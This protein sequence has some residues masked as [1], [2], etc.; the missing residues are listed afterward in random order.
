MITPRR[1]QAVLA[2]AALVAATLVVPTGTAE[3]QETLR[4][5]ADA[6]GLRM[7]A[8]VANDPLSGNTQ[9]RNIL[10]TEFNSVTA[11]NSMKWE[12]LQPSEGQFNWSQGDAIVEFAQDNNQ[13]VY[14]HTLVWHSQAPDW[15]QNLQGQQ[16]DSAMQTHISTVLNHYQGDVEAW[17][18]ANEVIDDDGD[19]RDSFWLEG[20]GP[21]YIADAFRYADA[22][23]PNAKLYINDYSID[24][25]NTKSNAYYDLVV[26]LLNQG[27]PIDGIGLQAHLILGQV[28]SSMEENIRR[29]ADLGLEVRITELDIRMDLPVTQAKLEQ[30]RDDYAA[31]VDACLAVDGCVG[32]TTWGFTDAFSWVPDWFDGQGAA[33]PFDESYNEKPA[34]DGILEALGGDPDNGGG[35]GDDGACEVSYSARDWGGSAGFTASVTI[36]NT[37]SGQIN[38]W[39]LGF[40]FPSGQTVTDGW[41]ADW[42]QNDADVTATSMGWNGALPP[43][44][45]TSIGFNGTHSGSNPAPTDFTLNGEPC[46]LG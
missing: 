29:F 3:A 28:P 39:T 23:D 1:R 27:V 4:G 6:Q 26:D 10:G 11:E 2:G 45:S 31:V 32:I 15:L 38:G 21:E 20:L 13:A 43:G 46:T 17:D 35:N 14:G 5:A 44:G 9:Y 16:L 42:S 12:S 19:L 7:G 36:T 25:I 22:A 37:G 18:V 41:S 33:L 40:R 8:A 24:G 34:Y 30:Q